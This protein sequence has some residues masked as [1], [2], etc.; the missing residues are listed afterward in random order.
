[1]FFEVLRP[2][3][4]TYIIGHVAGLPLAAGTAILKPSTGRQ[5]GVSLFLSLA[6]LF[7]GQGARAGARPNRIVPL[8]PTAQRR[9][10]GSPGRPPA[11]FLIFL[12][13]SPSAGRHPT[14]GRSLMRCCVYNALHRLML[15][16]S[17]SQHQA[18]TVDTATFD[19]IIDLKLNEA[20]PRRRTGRPSD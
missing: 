19:C 14:N 6:L 10:R 13:Y 8:P 4:G 7:S 3:E 18:I 17:I 5:S 20:R 2:G 16:Q 11:S 12:R 15:L 1:L 9:A